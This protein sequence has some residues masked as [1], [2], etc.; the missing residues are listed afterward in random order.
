MCPPPQIHRVRLLERL[1][2]AVLP[3]GALGA[4]A[5]AGVYLYLAPNLPSSENIRD[6]RLQVP[7]QV[8]TRDLRLIAE[9][10]EKRFS[11]IRLSEV[12]DMMV[13]PVLA[14]END[15]FLE[16]PGVD[17]KELLRAAVELAHSGE[18]G[19]G[20][21][22][23]I[24]QVARNFLLGREK[25]HSRKISE[26]LIASKIEHELSKD[27]I[28]ELYLNKIHLGQRANG[29]AAAAQVCCYGR[30]LGELTLAETAPVV[31]LQPAVVIA[32]HGAGSGRN[33]RAQPAGVARIGHREH[34]RPARSARRH[35]AE[36]RHLRDFSCGERAARDRD[37]SGRT[38]TEQL[39]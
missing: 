12:P 20:G 8:H 23:T 27:E 24:M 21:R 16:Q 25:T 3:L 2:Y 13:K 14:A 5:L 10:G 18:K 39:S 33:A 30:A 38:V 29:V 28:L 22:T 7:L 6:A 26:I 1:L 32:A 34:R 11:L 17:Y 19:Q 35:R 9:F 37:W 31:S 4:G 15:R 36:K